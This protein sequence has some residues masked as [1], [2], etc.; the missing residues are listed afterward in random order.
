M[1]V[2]KSNAREGEL[3]K[4]KKEME[5][6]LYLDL[7]PTVHVKCVMYSNVSGKKKSSYILDSVTLAPVQA[8]LPITD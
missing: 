6:L 7:A 1:A 3:Y 8:R 2:C 5:T 4:A